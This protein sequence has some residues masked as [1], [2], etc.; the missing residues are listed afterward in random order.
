VFHYNLI[1]LAHPVYA[2]KDQIMIDEQLSQELHLKT[3]TSSSSESQGKKYKRDNSVFP[4]NPPEV[5]L[6][7]RMEKFKTLKPHCIQ[8]SRV[9]VPAGTSKSTSRRHSIQAVTRVMAYVIDA[10]IL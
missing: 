2:L 7:Y 9:L 10:V 5:A 4:P 8:S 3:R 1:S 6:P